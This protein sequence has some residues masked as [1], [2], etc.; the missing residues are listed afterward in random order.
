M[1]SI[2]DKALAAGTQ[3]SLALERLFAQAQGQQDPGNSNL[4]YG[5]GWGW[6][7]LV[8]FFWV[9]VILGIIAAFRW[10]S[11]G[12]R[13][14]S[15]IVGGEGNPMEHNRALDILKERYARGEIDKQEYEEKKKD[16]MT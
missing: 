3:F 12:G 16:I 8:I 2:L 10:A 4:D 1:L 14:E 6:R 13:P 11:N 5:Y 9:L 15:G 7:T